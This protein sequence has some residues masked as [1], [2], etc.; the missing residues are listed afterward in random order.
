[1]DQKNL[2]AWTAPGAGFPAFVSLN[3]RNDEIVLDSRSQGAGV[4]GASVSL[5]R[6]VARELG[7]ALIQAT[8]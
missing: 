1:M 3:Q 6:A 8:N 5:D 4:A 2:F 7:L